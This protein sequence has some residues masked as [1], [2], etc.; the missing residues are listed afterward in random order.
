VLERRDGTEPG[1][2]FLLHPDLVGDGD[3]E[4]PEP[5]LLELDLLAQRIGPLLGLL[6]IQGTAGWPPR[7]PG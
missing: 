5:L 3:R 2:L 1:D 4:N 6:L 7:K